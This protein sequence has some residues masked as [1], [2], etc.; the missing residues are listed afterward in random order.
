MVSVTTSYIHG[1]SQSNRRM[2]SYLVIKVTFY[3]LQTLRQELVHPNNPIP[4]GREKVWYTAFP[5]MSVREPTLDR[6]AGHWTIALQSI[7]RLSRM[8]MWR[9]QQHLGHY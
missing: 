3:P 6:L 1:L 9:P 2:L 7:G 4:E 8:G 5:A